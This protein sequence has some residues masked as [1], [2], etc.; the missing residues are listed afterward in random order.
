MSVRECVCLCECVCVS[1]C[2]SVFARV[3]TWAGVAM[4]GGPSPVC[5]VQVEEVCLLDSGRDLEA[6]GVEGRCPLPGGPA[7]N[8]G[9]MNGRQVFRAF[10]VPCALRAFCV[11]YEQ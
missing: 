5:T 3:L 4:G 11:Y 8:H 6:G 1:V 2:V 10:S 9:G 7:N